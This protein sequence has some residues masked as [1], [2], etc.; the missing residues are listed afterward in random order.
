MSP[1][2]LLAGAPWL[3]APAS[4]WVMGALQ[5][6]GR[7]ARFVG[8][9]IRDHLLGR[10]ARRPDLDIATQEPPER[11]IELLESE[12][13]KTIP[14]GLAHG[15]VTAVL[16]EQRFEI[17]TLRCDVACDGR[18]ADVVFTDDFRLDA[19][20]RDF[21]INAM[22]CDPDG[23]LFDDFGG[24]ADLRAG[25]IRFVGE[26]ASR[27][28]EDR[29]RILRFFRFFA[30]YGRPPADPPALAAARAGASGIEAL[31][32][33]RVQAEMLKLLA[34][35][36]PLR[37]LELM[38]ETSVLAHVL[39]MPVNLG[40]LQALLAL[41]PDADPLLRLAALLRPHETAADWVGERWRLSK[42]DLERLGFLTSHELPPMNA[43]ARARRRWLHRL[44]AERF[45]ALARL[46]AADVGNGGDH[47]SEAVRA[48]ASWTPKVLPV[49]GD[50]VLA[51]GVPPGPE[52]G[53]ALATLEAWW[54]EG[55]FAA[56]RDAC[57]AEL[58]QLVGDAP[59]R[60]QG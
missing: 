53:E 49:G 31:S 2:R 32:G 22:S 37:A 18:H 33:E 55:D 50:D 16:G 14:T 5:A 52:V 38:V 15:T 13:I 42:R 12:G 51:L 20:R 36:D 23:R 30:R 10:S 24:L 25:R 40:R 60:P 26:P 6:G 21:T 19:A 4:R 57:L 59:G 27:I 7:E 54:A 17:T 41:A 47:L 3:D 29:L 34:A 45:L 56:D 8:G 1:G 43:S 11:V 39:P 44:G 48:A 58:A 46:A 28:E 35:S 9:C